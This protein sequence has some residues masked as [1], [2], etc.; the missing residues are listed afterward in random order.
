MEVVG[1][2]VDDVFEVVVVELKGIAFG[3]AFDFWH[4]AGELGMMLGDRVLYVLFVCCMLYILSV[5]EM[6]VLGLQLFLWLVFK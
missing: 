5:F 3:G 2:R 6:F 1:N 4:A